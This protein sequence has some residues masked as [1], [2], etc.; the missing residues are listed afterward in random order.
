MRQ[1]SDV[2]GHDHADTKSPDLSHVLEYVMKLPDKYR[3]IVYLHY[4][5]GYSAGEIAGI[6]HKNVNTIYTHLSRAKAGAAQNEMGG[7][8][9]LSPALCHQRPG[10]SQPVLHESS[11]HQHRCEPRH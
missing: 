1:E 2:G 5:E 8:P 9:C 7:I 11:R 4:Y 6:L 3:I 10:R